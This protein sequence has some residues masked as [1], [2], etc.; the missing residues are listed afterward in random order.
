MHCYPDDAKQFP[1]A[2]ATQNQQQPI[3]ELVNQIL[4]KKRSSP[5][6]DTSD[7]EYQIDELVYELYGITEEEIAMIEQ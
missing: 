7:L 4:T 1:I 5:N 2:K 6:A 3:I